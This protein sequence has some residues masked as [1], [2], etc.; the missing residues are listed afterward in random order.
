[1]APQLSL[2]PANKIAAAN[3]CFL[4]SGEG[5]KKGKHFHLMASDGDEEEGRRTRQLTV[6]RPVN[7]WAQMVRNN[8]RIDGGDTRLCQLA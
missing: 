7:D 6:K 5:K 3:L 4:H 1:M 2:A 8:P